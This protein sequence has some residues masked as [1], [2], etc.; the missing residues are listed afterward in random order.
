MIGTWSVEIQ[1][2]GQITVVA[3]PFSF[4]AAFSKHVENVKIASHWFDFVRFCSIGSIGSKIE[5]TA[6]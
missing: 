2:K 5:L 1:S 4:H 6:K 3:F